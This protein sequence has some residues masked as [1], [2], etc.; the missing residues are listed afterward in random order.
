MRRRPGNAPVATRQDRVVTRHFDIDI[1]FESERDGVLHGQVKH[2][3]AHQAAD[4]SGIFEGEWA[5][6]AG[7][8]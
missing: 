5:E 3:G 8:R 4:A 1:V 6:L 7:G 2:A